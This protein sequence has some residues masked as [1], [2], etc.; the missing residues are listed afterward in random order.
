MRSY[1]CKSKKKWPGCSGKCSEIFLNL[2]Q[3]IQIASPI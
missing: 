3:S 1:S 2:Y